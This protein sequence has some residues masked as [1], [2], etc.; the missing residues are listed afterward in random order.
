MFK[1]N[2]FD[3]FG[4]FYINNYLRKGN[5]LYIERNFDRKYFDWKIIY[6]FFR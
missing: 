2:F 4:N 5:I 1:Y 3:M 6:F